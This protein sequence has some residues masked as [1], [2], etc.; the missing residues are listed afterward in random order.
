MEPADAGSVVVVV[1]IVGVVGACCDGCS[2]SP[3]VHNFHVS[4]DYW[5]CATR[6][7]GQG[8]QEVA[9]FIGLINDGVGLHGGV[10][11]GFRVG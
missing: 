3:F 10:V 2:C 9:V 1:I 7:V 5:L 11:G 6:I 8:A 4:S